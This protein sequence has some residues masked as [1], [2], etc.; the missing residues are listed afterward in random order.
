MRS[1]DWSPDVCS[2]DL[3]SLVYIARGCR[4]MKASFAS[5]P[6]RVTSTPKC[7]N[8]SRGSQPGRLN[9]AL[10]AAYR[11]RGAAPK[12]HLESTRSEEQTSELQ[13][14]MRSSSAVF[15]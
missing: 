2:S 6:V 3:L 10:H 8:L 4:L 12:S 5:G 1:S 9:F 15:C 14:L 7:R 13:S 11:G